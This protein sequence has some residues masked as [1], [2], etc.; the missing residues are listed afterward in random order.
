MGNPMNSINGCLMLFEV[1]PYVAP[2]VGVEWRCWI[3]F[4]QSV[5]ACCRVFIVVT[6]AYERANGKM[7]YSCIPWRTGKQLGKGHEHP[8]NALLALYPT[9]LVCKMFE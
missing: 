5:V 2:K 6:C 8:F 9:V 3:P 7:V 4:K 1:E